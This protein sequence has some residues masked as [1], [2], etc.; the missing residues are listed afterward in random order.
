MNQR[1]C[2]GLEE[3]KAVVE[4]ML[5]V[6]AKKP[7]QP[8]AVAVVDRHGMLICYAAMDGCNPFNQEM[9]IKKAR[10]V[11]FVGADTSQFAQGAKMTGRLVA[12]FGTTE[13]TTVPGGICL[14]NPGTKAVIGGIGT[15][16]RAADEDEAIARAGLNALKL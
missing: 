11:V 5:E 13:I 1:E 4:A 8:E 16:G 10:T 2:I 15:S 7:H 9:A 14:R 6:S 3:A 12:D